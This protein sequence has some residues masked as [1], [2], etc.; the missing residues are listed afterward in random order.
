[1][2]D[3]VHPSDYNLSNLHKSMQYDENGN[4]SVR[5]L[6]YQNPAVMSSYQRMRTIGTRYMD[7]YRF[8]YGESTAIFEIISLTAGSGSYSID[9]TNKYLSLTV[10]TSV[11][12]R[13][14]IQSKQ[15]HNYLCSTTMLFYISF[16]MNAP[17]AGLLQ[18]VGCYDDKDGIFFRLNGLTPEIVIRKQYIETQVIPQ[19]DWNM[20]KFLD[21]DFS[22]GQTIAIEH[23]WMGVGRV[24][25][26]FMRN[27]EL[28]FAHQFIY[29]NSIDTT[30]INQPSLP[31]RWE[32]LN[33]NSTST[34]STFKA[35]CGSVYAEGTDIELGFRRSIS[36]GLQPV[37]INSNVG[38]GILAF[39][40]KNTVSGYTNRSSAR[41][42]AYN[43]TTTNDILYRIVMLPSSAMIQ[44]ATW[45]DMPGRSFC[46]YATNLELV[47][48]WQTMNFACIKES[49]VYSTNPNKSG[50][51][52]EGTEDDRS[53][54]VFQN[55][56]A[57][58]S[59]IMM[60]IG[61]KLTHDAQ[62]RANM[63]WIEIK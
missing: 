61:F 34:A 21:I 54:H 45:Q 25:V 62:V 31:V 47:P 29:T 43:I 24:R 49:H 41:I 5:V 26:G 59:Q 44:S 55:Y 9:Y 30:F 57:T 33:A 42:K 27:G 37:T 4:P 6:S 51:D 15:C 52:A 17:T 8:M 11:N 28:V 50:Q 40:L 7:E 16:I 53:L 12:D 20:D 13:V 38:K 36:T 48:N 18:S 39:R 60:I 56:D 14:V 19:T 2:S 3:Y 46:Q 10:G 35:I 23:D 22:K 32:L 58:D 63:S 1:M